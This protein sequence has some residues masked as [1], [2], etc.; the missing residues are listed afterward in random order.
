MA[1]WRR[2]HGN[3]VAAQ[4]QKSDFYRSEAVIDAARSA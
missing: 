2:E 4:R 1:Q 3:G